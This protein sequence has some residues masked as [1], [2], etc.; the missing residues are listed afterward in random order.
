MFIK[1]EPPLKNELKKW[2]NNI[3]YF[4]DLKSTDF[5]SCFFCS[6]NSNRHSIIT[7]YNFL[8]YFCRI[9]SWHIF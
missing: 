6:G 3:E 1:K 8:T 9:P 4:S 2:N 5:D 7:S